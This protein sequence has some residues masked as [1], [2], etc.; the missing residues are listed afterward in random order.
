MFQYRDVLVSLDT[1]VSPSRC[2]IFIPYSCLMARH[3]RLL[4]RD[5]VVPV[6]YL[7]F[8]ILCYFVGSYPERYVSSPL[9]IFIS[10]KMGF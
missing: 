9:V 1:E 5:D 7:N 4:G 6:T 2:E 10:P 8:F 3:P